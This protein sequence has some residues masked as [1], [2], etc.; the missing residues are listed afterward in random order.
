[1]YKFR[2][3]RNRF[4]NTFSNLGF[5]PEPVPRTLQNLGF[6]KVPE[7]VP[8]PVGPEPFSKFRIPR[9]RFWNTFYKFRVPRNRL[10]NT[11]YKFRVPRNR[12]WNLFSNLGFFPEPVPRTL[13][14]L[15]FSEPVPRTGSGPWFMVFISYDFQPCTN[16]YCSLCQ[17]E[18]IHKSLQ[19]FDSSAL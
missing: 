8:V 6:L 7:P 19:A 9:N 15:G 18:V 12:F 13:Q 16:T 2:V 10:W 1:L 17:D 11:F 3:P 5:H 4:S 14:N